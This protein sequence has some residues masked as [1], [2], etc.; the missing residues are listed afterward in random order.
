MARERKKHLVFNTVTNGTLLSAQTC[1][2]LLDNDVRVIVSLDGD[3]ELNDQTKKY[4][5]SHYDTV[6]AL[7]QPFQDELQPTIRSTISKANFR[8]LERIL[9]SFTEMSWPIAVFEEIGAGGDDSLCLTREDTP[10]LDEQ[11]ERIFTRLVEETGFFR[12]RLIYPFTQTLLQIAFPRKNHHR[13]SAGRRTLAVD[14]QGNIF[15]CHRMVGIPE[16]RVGSLNEP[17]DFSAL[18]PY[19]RADINSKKPC[20][21]C[22]A[23]YLC[24]GGCVRAA[25]EKHNDITK[26][27]GLLCAHTKKMLE[28]GLYYSTRIGRL[29]LLAVL[30]NLL[31]SLRNSPGYYLKESDWELLEK[32]ELG[33]WKYIR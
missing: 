20:S 19:Y 27:D 28:K 22:W 1:R 3:K 32:A 24:S 33:W 4:G 11:Y 5:K 29:R 25:F 30:P 9:D 12:P 17:F 14:T 16:Q 2:F 18:E 31:R 13:C 10:V 21:S 26:P 23:R 15:P 7:L 8:H 6:R